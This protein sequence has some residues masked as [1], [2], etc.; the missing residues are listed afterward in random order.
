MILVS[1]E[2]S[3]FTELD[4]HFADFMI[5][6]AGASEPEL[7]IAAALVSQVTQ[8]GHV[9]LDLP[10]YAGRPFPSGLIIPSAGETLPDLECWLS[11]LRRSVVVGE[12]GQYRPLI[13]DTSNRL[14]L[15][16]YWHY[17]QRLLEF[18][19][20]RVSCPVE[21][22]PL[23]ILK[24]G[25]QR[26]FP[27]R[28]SEPDWQ[29]IAALIS[30]LRR[31]AVITGGPG[32]GKTSTVVRIL[33]LLLEQAGGD[34]Y[35]IALAAPTGKAASRLKET[36][37]LAKEALDCNQE[38]LNLV[39]VEASTL[40]R[41]LGTV[42][43]STRFRHHRGNPLPYDA[44]VVDEASMV[45]LPL[46]TKLVDA[47]KNESRLILLGDK[48]QLASV[49]PGAVFGDICRASRG[50]SFSPGFRATMQ[51]VLGKEIPE[52]SQPDPPGKLQD[53]IVLLE[54]SYRFGQGSGIGILSRIVN[55]GGVEEALR[56]LKEGHFRDLVYREIGPN[57]LLETDLEDRVLEDCAAYLR[58]DDIES[59]FDAFPRFRILCA[60][61]G[62]DCGVETLN[63][64]LEKLLVQ[65]G[66]I[67]R[68]APW[69]R[70][71][72][73][74]ITEND[75]QLKVFNGDIGIVFPTESV[76]SSLDQSFWVYLPAEG[77]GFRRIPPLRL[78]GHET[79]YAMTVHKS[80]GSEFDRVLLILPPHPSEVLTREL[81]YTG[82][83]RARKRLEIWGNDEVIRWAISRRTE[84]NSGLRDALWPL[85][86]NT[87]IKRAL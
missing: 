57:S 7:W 79:A 75:Y 4:R 1:Q 55:E 84:R 37:R 69:Y 9:C 70:G 14:Y 17:E 41:L 83:T 5:Q 16:R 54:K 27:V 30:V 60:L 10:Q 73:I 36:V 22:R 71:R 12:P 39:P 26:L 15:Y 62:G 11:T 56:V 48:D 42:P 45:D 38:I 49:E 46:M 32:T 13:L 53:S 31:F 80:Q 76:G 74:L 52:N 51:A 87:D 65:K 81:I 8:R 47:L 24:M 50:N 66:L 6:L 78:P 25:L 29:M 44:V 61:R 63:Q 58:E 3:G 19:K 20:E 34:K 2:R 18:L 59:A 23:E 43:D 72:P 68:R 86:E 64:L 82:I 33:V 67:R 77:G 85:P 28:D 40:H 21:I 35:R